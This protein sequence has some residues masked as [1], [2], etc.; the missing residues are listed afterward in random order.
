MAMLAVAVVGISTMPATAY[1]VSYLD[2]GTWNT[3]FTQG[4]NTKLGATP[5][6]G[7]PD[8]TPVALSKFEFFKSGTADS[9]S[10]I[11]LA[12][13]NNIFTDMSGG[14]TTSNSAFV[15][16]SSNTIASTA[17]IATGDPVA[18]DFANL[19]LSA[20]GNY[21]AVF[22]NVGPDMGGTSTLTPVRVSAL[23]AN[24]V[25]VGGGVFQPA[26][27]YGGNDNFLLATSNFINNGFFNTF[28]FAGDANF[29]ATLRVVPEPGTL[30]IGL[31]VCVGA[32]AVVRRRA[33]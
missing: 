32:G 27:N 18:F 15:G 29:R 19:A 23:T 3:V 11:R 9:A 10:N 22:V 24:Y 13:L 30:V 16:L 8:G 12:I 25:D 26:T 14:L 21:A 28:S 5:D 4:F 7:V 20:G 17:G 31:A 6:P 2:G 1:T 33:G